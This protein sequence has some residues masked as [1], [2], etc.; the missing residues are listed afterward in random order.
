[1]GACLSSL[2]GGGVAE[3]ADPS[4]TP[5]NWAGPPRTTDKA[6]LAATRAEI[7][8]LVK[9]EGCAPVLVRLA[10]HDAG[11]FDATSTAGFPGAGGA[12]GSIRFANEQAHAANAGLAGSALKLLAPIARAHPRVSFADLFQCA[13][14]TAVEASGG[15]RIPMRYGRADAPGPTSLVP[16]GRLPHGGP[17][18]PAGATGPAQHL[19][20]VFI[21]R[22]GLSPRAL[23]ALS[24]AHT[25]GRCKPDRSGFGKAVT[26]Y[27]AHPPRGAPGG[28]PWT[29]DYL[30]FN[31][32]D[33]FQAVL[34][35]AANGGESVDP[36]LVVLETDVTLA[37]DPEFR[38]FTERYAKDGASF[39]KDYAAAHAEL[40]ELGVKWGAGGPF[41]L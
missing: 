26:R 7:E 12:N 33:Y 35:A 4:P 28:S 15:P 22:L 9:S 17:P 23:V 25:L 20:A 19:R 13:G 39:R 38:P 8:A 24:G 40:S 5:F 10:W 6:D 41:S 27:T 29:P 1:M 34:E 2:P 3:D 18:Y 36:D 11:T 37:T 31:G 30:T 14:A 32:P 16:E 21:D